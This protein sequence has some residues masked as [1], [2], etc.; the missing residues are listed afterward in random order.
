MTTLPSSVEGDRVPEERETLEEGPVEGNALVGPGD[1]DELHEE[2][3]PGGGAVGGHVELEGAHLPGRDRG[4]QGDPDDLDF[5]AGAP[6]GVQGPVT[7]HNPIVDGEEEVV[8]L[9]ATVA[10]GEVVPAGS[11]VVGGVELEEE[12]LDAEF[13]ATVCGDEEAQTFRPLVLRGAVL[14]EGDRRLGG[15]PLE[16]R[17]GDIVGGALGPEDLS[18]DEADDLDL[19]VDPVELEQHAGVGDDFRVGGHVDLHGGVIVRGDVHFFAAELHLAFDEEPVGLHGLA[20]HVLV[21][22]HD[23]RDGLVV[24]AVDEREVGQLH[25]LSDRLETEGANMDVGLSADHDV[26]AGSAGVLAHF[27]VAPADAGV[28]IAGLEGGRGGGGFTAREGKD[29]EGEAEH[30]D[31][32]APENRSEPFIGYKGT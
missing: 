17:A 5:A 1:I 2:L 11:F 29:G 21:P 13:S 8:L 22:D 25:R 3:I 32:D 7:I 19:V 12:L 14:G 10:A 23:A 9:E 24:V 27:E 30:G 26:G 15:V 18:G 6:S 31:S 16:D 4:V 28:G 20:V